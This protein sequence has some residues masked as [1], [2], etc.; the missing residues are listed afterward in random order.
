MCFPRGWRGEQCHNCLTVL[1]GGTWTLCDW[2]AMV[3]GLVLEEVWQQCQIG[4]CDKQLNRWKGLIINSLLLSSQRIRWPAEAVFK[5][6]ANLSL[7]RC[8]L[9]HSLPKSQCVSGQRGGV[10]GSKGVS[11]PEVWGS[12]VC[13]GDR[14][15]NTKRLSWY[16]MYL[17]AC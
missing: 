6:V 7:M 8:H 3:G 17:L 1:V 16:L 15:E 9:P 13:G 14:V 2:K 12:H 5:V 11:W 4:N 10:G